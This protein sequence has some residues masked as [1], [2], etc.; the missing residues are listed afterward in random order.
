MKRRDLEKIIKD[1]TYQTKY[2]AIINVKNNEIF[3]YEA[4]AKFNLNKHLLTT[5]EIFRYLHHNNALFYELEQRNKKH[6]LKNAT[7]TEKLFINFDADIVNTEEQKSYW[8]Q[9]LTPFKH[10]I[11]VEITENGSDDEKSAN[12][13][14]EFSTWLKSRGI[15]SALDDFGQEGSMFSFFIMNNSQYVKIDKS[16]LRQIEFNPHYLYYLQGVIKTLQANG[17]ETI[18]EGVE[19]K[20][21]YECVKALG[22]N[23]MQGYYFND[24]MRII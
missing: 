6:Q 24:L 15:V 21:D 16:F 12:I 17:Q 5:E 1:T 8:E 7:F 9:F 3:G 18:I 23:Y 11:V 22:S 4:L 13:M 19:T 10:K 14:K 2:E 20:E